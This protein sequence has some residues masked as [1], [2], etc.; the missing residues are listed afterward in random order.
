MWPH[1]RFARKVEWEA[2]RRIDGVS[3]VARIIDTITGDGPDIDP[4][5]ITAALWL[6]HL[7]GFVLFM[8]PG[9]PG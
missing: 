2:L 9:M 4:A 6:L 5:A 3:S 7:E 8:P 1:R